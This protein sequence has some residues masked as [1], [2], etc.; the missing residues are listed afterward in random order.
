MKTQ[1]ERVLDALRRAGQYGITQ[2][3]MYSP[4]DGGP[5]IARLAAR[6]LEL[7]DQGHQIVSDGRR[8][9]CAVY[10]LTEPASRPLPLAAAGRKG[11]DA[12]PPPAAS[13]PTPLDTP[14]VGGELQLFEDA[15]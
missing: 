5:P 4:G 8:N 3:E 11:G 13:P 14:L 10:V 2:V 12:S 15:A 6:V 1:A 7:R 9:K